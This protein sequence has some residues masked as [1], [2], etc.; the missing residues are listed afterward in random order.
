MIQKHLFLMISLILL[1]GFSRSFADQPTPP[2]ITEGTGMADGQGP[3]AREEAVRKALKNAIENALGV[4]VDSVTLVN[5][6]TLLEESVYTHVDGYVKTYQILRDNKGANGVT[7]ITVRAEI[8]KGRLES[9]LKAVKLILSAKSNPRGM[10]L[11]MERSYGEESDLNA[12][13]L[14]VEEFLRSKTLD[15]VDSNQLRAIRERDTILYAD[16]PGKSRALAARYGAEFIITGSAKLS[17]GSMSV[18]YGIPVY[19]SSATLSLKAVD[20]DTG[21]I[22]AILNGTGNGWGGTP[23]QASQEAL[24]TL[25]DEK[26]EAFFRALMESFREEVFNTLS[27]TLMISNCAPKDRKPVKAGLKSVPG[28]L[29]LS[30]KSYANETLELAATIDATALPT[31]EERISGRFPH[32]LL[33]SKTD[34]RMDFDI[35]GGKQR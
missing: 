14:M 3:A 5:N 34:Q 24:K 22:L 20:A 30:E 19:A 21:R 2:F 33:T 27:V 29:S 12:A 18:S 25:F 7:E 28:I 35:S 31:M 26:K 11:I 32:F 9:E 8:E 16:N 23:E 15:L 6:Q 17:E 4:M 13:T 10:V 1:I